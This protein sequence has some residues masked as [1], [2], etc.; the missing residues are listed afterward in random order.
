MGKTVLLTCKHLVSQ[1]SIE[2][3]RLE[4][5][6]HPAQEFVTVSEGDTAPVCGSQTYNTVED[7]PVEK[8]LRTTVLEH[9]TWEKTFVIETRFVSEREL[10]DQ[11]RVRFPEVL[12]FPT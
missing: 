10:T 2:Q 3:W 9:H 12:V 4:H 7:R 11:T 6:A 1:A 5:G 8:E